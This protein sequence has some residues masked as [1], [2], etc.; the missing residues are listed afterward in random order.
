ML[1]ETAITIFAEKTIKYQEK[2]ET[3]ITAN[4]ELQAA[5]VRYNTK[6]A[7]FFAEREDS[8]NN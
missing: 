5:F 6:R 1:A 8:A 4:P 3:L 7:D 2:V